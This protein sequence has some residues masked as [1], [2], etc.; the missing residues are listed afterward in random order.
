M[1]KDIERNN[2]EIIRIEISEFKGRELINLRI[3]Y[4]AI[5]GNGDMVY[6]PSQKGVA[7]NLSKYQEL[8]DGIDK[9]GEYLKDKEEGFTAEDL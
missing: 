4:S 1:I 3:W 5:D 8:K 9:I 7:L 2:K 6:K